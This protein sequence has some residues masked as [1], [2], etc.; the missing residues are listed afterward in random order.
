MKG[1]KGIYILCTNSLMKYN[2]NKAPHVKRQRY[3]TWDKIYFIEVLCLAEAQSTQRKKTSAH[4]VS[5]REI[6][7]APNSILSSVKWDALYKHY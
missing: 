3:T 2:H 6:V 5:L 7:L 4:P 1:G